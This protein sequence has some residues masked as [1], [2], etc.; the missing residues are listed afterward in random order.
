MENAKSI[1]GTTEVKVNGSEKTA[2]RGAAGTKRA[3]G[4]NYKGSNGSNDGSH[5]RVLEL[6]AELSKTRSE[7]ET[8]EAQYRTLLD[9]LSEMKNKIG[10]KLQQDAVGFSFQVKRCIRNSF[11]ANSLVVHL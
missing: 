2:D 11:M 5:G 1:N 6:E 3:S 8:L 7:K 4:G 9:R 10:L